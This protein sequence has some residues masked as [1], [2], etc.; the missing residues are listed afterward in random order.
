MEPTRCR[1]G[2]AE[3]AHLQSALA[4]AHS[5]LP[6]SGQGRCLVAAPRVAVGGV[7][8]Q[9]AHHDEARSGEGEPTV[10]VD[11]GDLG[12]PGAGEV[13]VE[14]ELHVGELA[15]GWG[16]AGKDRPD[17]VEQGA[18]PRR[19]KATIA[20]PPSAATASEV[21]SASTTTPVTPSAP[22]ARGQV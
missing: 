20:P 19:G 6:S 9:A 15:Q 1:T 16:P 14:G 4:E 8:D 12:P 17:V 10:V 22:R 11:L 13:G 18:G 21:A 2:A 3:L 7:F 5:H